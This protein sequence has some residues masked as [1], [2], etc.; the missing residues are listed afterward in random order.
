MRSLLLVTVVLV[1]S[2]TLGGVASADPPGGTQDDAWIFRL[3]T[4]RGEM[5]DDDE[6]LVAIPAG[7]AWGI[8]SG[9]LRLPPS[10]TVISAEIEVRDA[11]VREAFLR[12]AFYER[13]VGRPRQIS[14]QDSPPVVAG[15]R[16]RVRMR[17]DPPD[18]AVAYRVRVLG[19]LAAGPAMSSSGAIA[20][21]ELLLEGAPPTPRARRTR[22]IADR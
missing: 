21:R 4:P 7:R 5:I 9:L 17:L 18:G 6:L 19:R 14:V 8:A 2:A 10:G 16:T 22:L 13:V 1:S 20:V 11:R 12:A 15:E 3:T